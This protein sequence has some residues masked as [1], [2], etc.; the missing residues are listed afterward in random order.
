M[1]QGIRPYHIPHRVSVVTVTSCQQKPQGSAL[2]TRCQPWFSRALKGAREGLLPRTGCRRPCR[3]TRSTTWRP[4]WVPG[5]CAPAGR[6][7]A[8]ALRSPAHVVAAHATAA[9]AAAQQ[10]HLGGH[11][12]GGVLFH[13]VLVGVLARLQAPFDVDRAA[14]LQVFAGDLGH[15]VE[16]DHAVPFGFFLALAAGLVLPLAA[17]GHRDVADGRAAGQR[18]A[19]RG[20][21]RGC[22]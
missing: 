16:E 8:R 12:V 11:D 4:A 14:L 17:G 10:L 7:A 5:R 19:P 13:A 22:R 1:P 6:C 20:P 3:R 9:F 18:S 15:A 21:C 2:I